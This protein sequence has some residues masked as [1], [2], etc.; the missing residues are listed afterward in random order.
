MW[1]RR[2]EFKEDLRDVNTHVSL[3]KEFYKNSDL[4]SQSWDELEI[5]IKKYFSRISNKGKSKEGHFLLRGHFLLLSK[6]KLYI[7]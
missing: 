6:G 3:V 7:L 2:M 4:S 5:L 1:N